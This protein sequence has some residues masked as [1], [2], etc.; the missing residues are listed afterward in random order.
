MPQFDPSFFSTQ[1]FWLAVTFVAL[2]AVLSTVALP[3]IGSVLDER[4]RKIDDNLDKAA[5]LKAETETA[6]AVYEKA[7]AESRAQAQQILRTSA[8]ALAKQSE[9]SQKAAGERLSAQI[10]AGEAKILAAKDQALTHVREIAVEVA[11]TAAGKLTG[12]TIDEGQIAG[13]VGA[14]IQEGR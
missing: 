1:L 4:Q 8:D 3:K 7:L 11:K 14:A 9:L 2:Y 12:L 13:A 10:K 5:Q 6:I